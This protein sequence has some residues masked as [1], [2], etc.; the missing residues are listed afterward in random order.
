MTAA[1]DK[2]KGKV[3]EVVGKGKQASNKP[4]TRAEGRMQERKGEAQQVKGRA[5]SAL[6]DQIDKA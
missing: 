3:N 5:K 2:V 1:K 4:S 6:K